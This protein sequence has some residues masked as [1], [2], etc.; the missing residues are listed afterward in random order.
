[1]P[2]PSLRELC[3]HHL[4]AS[5]DRF[6]ERQWSDGRFE[7]EREHPTEDWNFYHDQYLLAA[8]L[9]Y[10]VEHPANPWREDERL[11]QAILRNGRHLAD[12]IADDGTMRWRLN[13]HDFRFVCQRLLC[14]WSLSYELL[15]DRLSTE[16]ERAWR[17]AAL[18]GAEW[19][20]QRHVWPHREVQGF[21]SHDVGT[22]TNHF[23]LYLSLLY[24]LGMQFDRPQWVEVTVPLMRRLIAAQAPGG[25][26]AEHHGPA[27]GYNTL[28]YHGVQE[29]TAWSGDE[30][31]AEAL[32][33]GL[34]L[35]QHWT[36]ADGTPI[37]CIDGRMRHIARPFL[38]GL[39][40]F[41]REAEGRGY[42]RLLLEK[43]DPQHLSGENAAKLAEAYLLL[44]DGEE[45]TPPQRRP[46]YR[47]VLDG[48]SVARKEGPWVVALSGQC[49][50][51]WED[52]PFA[53]DRQAL[54]SVW[55]ETVGLVIDGSNSKH[56][57]ELATLRR[58]GD[59]LPLAAELRPS[60]DGE[61]TLDVRYATFEGTLRA[62]IV[63]PRTLDLI[64]SA[65]TGEST[66]QAVITLVPAVSYGATATMDVGGSREERALGDDAFSFDVWEHGGELS[67]AGVRL[68]LPGGTRVVYPVSPFNSYTP[69]HTSPPSANRLLVTCPVSS[70]GVAFRLMV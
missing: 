22:G 45:E 70:G 18:R 60:A 2:P 24:R 11:W 26:W 58:E 30:A 44:Q 49:S 29:Y 59:S 32:R 16:D 69:D 4:V 46:C 6:L 62:R 34:D 43:T 64:F 67:F 55:H 63:D 61:E 57:P 50:P 66:G 39:A 40:G 56:Q 19:L 33:R 15:R 41:S 38:W 35:H 21:T 8:S 54:V 65:R 51:N 5:A 42:A 68:L 12:Q 13:G 52:N 17:E 10:T 20:W 14:A 23:A 25:Y 31:G 28:T 27:L 37:E 1:M 7:A 48:V 47:A 9:L 53:L 3:L 36:F